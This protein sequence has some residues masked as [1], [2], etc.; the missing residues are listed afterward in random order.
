MI[1]SLDHAEIQPI[2]DNL[3]FAQG[4]IGYGK[5]CGC[6]F[7]LGYQNGLHGNYIS[8]I[9]VAANLPDSPQTPKPL[10]DTA[11][12]YEQG[13]TIGCN[14]AAKMIAING[15]KANMIFPHPRRRPNLMNWQLLALFPI[16]TRLV[17][18]VYQGT[19]SQCDL[20]VKYWKYDATNQV[21]QYPC[22]PKHIHWVADIL[23]KNEFTPQDVS[24]FIQ[25]L[26]YDWDHNIIQGLSTIGD[27]T[28]FL[29]AEN[30]FRYMYIELF[31]YPNI[32]NRGEYPL[33]FIIIL[34][35][36]LMVQERTN[37][38]HAYF[39]R[40]VLDYLSQNDFYRTINQATQ[41]HH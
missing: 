34:A 20:I 3:P 7:E 30:M 15:Y 12:A 1:C 5:C 36:L 23:I 40:K 6:A 41:T 28:I 2:I 18:G 24:K 29:N 16:S 37:N 17:I 39:F 27:R 35:R 8:F 14:I 9:N 26:Q 22:Q 31:K 33:D 38:P 25:N 19:L 10:R 11:V 32:Q 13:F 21:W 4:G